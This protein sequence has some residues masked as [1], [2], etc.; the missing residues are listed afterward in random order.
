M[1]T[2]WL[3]WCGWG[4]CAA[5]LAGPVGWLA[6]P[7]KTLDDARDPPPAA[8]SA[9]MA[10]GECYRYV[11]PAAAWRLWLACDRESTLPAVLDINVRRQDDRAW[12]VSGPPR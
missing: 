6:L 3:L 1:R 12:I 9:R 7:L 2:G 8:V 11:Q 5:G 4:V 10:A